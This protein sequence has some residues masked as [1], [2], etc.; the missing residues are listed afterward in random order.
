MAAGGRLRARF[1]R[2][3]RLRRRK[4]I[5][6]VFSEGQSWASGP[7]RVV[8]ALLDRQEAPLQVAFAVSRKVGSAVLRNRIR[9]RMR[10]VYRIHKAPLLETFRQRSHTLALVFIFRGT[11]SVSFAELEGAMRSL[12]ETLQAHYGT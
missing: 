10:E 11:A 3:E 9:R 12:I 1:P 5:A 4:L 2:A 8:A 7:I 6:R